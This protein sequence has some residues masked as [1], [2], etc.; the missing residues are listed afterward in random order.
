MIGWSAKSGNSQGRVRR[1]ALVCGALFVGLVPNL[2]ASELAGG[3]TESGAGEV[4]GAH[5]YA[6]YVAAAGGV[7][8]S[9]TRV[10]LAAHRE[11]A[12]PA[13]AR[14]YNMACSACH[15][16]W[17]ELNAFGQ[18]FKDNGYQ[19]GNDR[20]S[21]IWVN[22]SYIP[23]AIRTTPGWRMERT[24]HQPVDDGLGGTVEKTITQSGFDISGADL[25]MLGTLYKDITFGFVPTVEDGAGVGIEAAF[26]RFDN[27][28]KSRWVNLKIGK[29]ELDNMLSEKRSM[30][31]SS[32]GTFYQSYHFAPAG[33]AS[34]FGLGDNQIGA[35]W[36]GH[37]ANS[38]T[39]FSVAVLGS[40]DG[41]PG[42]A[43]R[44][45]LRR[46]GHPESGVRRRQAR[47]RADRGVWLRR[48]AAH[49]LRDH[50]RRRPGSRHRHRQQVVLPG[51]RGRR[52]LPRE[53]RAAAALHARLRRAR[54]WPAAPAAP[55]G[56]AGSS[57]LHYYVNPQLVFTQRSELI[58]MSHQALP[59]RRASWATSTPSP[60]A[61]AG[62]RSCSAGPGSPWSARC[63]SPRRSAR[64]R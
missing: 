3:R 24:T 37:S 43:R 60:S 30:M 12:I 21:P 20:D 51:R 36:L 28:F 38:Y 14:K 15:T 40:V 4:D 52:L 63:R 57:R 49:D 42:P 23:F 32:N 41:D 53:A 1:S 47:T 25:L 48:P 31:L 17:P 22:P 45:E 18:T 6:A 46:L 9:G 27:L 7:L 62:T 39:R 5:S 10:T 55:P 35:E 26:V 2:A 16:A 54:I 50:Q 61:I 56:T 11:A 59:R 8:P 44:E 13:F 64:C 58:R 34:G 19:L 33:S 29:F